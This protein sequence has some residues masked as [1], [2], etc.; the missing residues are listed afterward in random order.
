MEE[1]LAKRFAFYS[2]ADEKKSRQSRSINA[3]AGCLFL[4]LVC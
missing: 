1:A 2:V 3:A 4:R